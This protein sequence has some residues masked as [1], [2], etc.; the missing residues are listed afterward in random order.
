VNAVITIFGDFHQCLF[1]CHRQCIVIN[2][3]M[4]KTFCWHYLHSFVPLN[5][6]HLVGNSLKKPFRI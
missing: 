6:L 2:A 3:N 4:Y 5:K 1:M